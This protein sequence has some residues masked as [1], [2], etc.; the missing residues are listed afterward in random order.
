MVELRLVRIL[1][2]SRAHVRRPIRAR[3]LALHKGGAAAN[4][5]KGSVNQMSKAIVDMRN[6]LEVMFE[7]MD[8][9][10]KRFPGKKGIVLLSA[11]QQV[12]RDQSHAGVMIPYYDE[13][14]NRNFV[15]HELNMRV[16]KSVEQSYVQTVMTQG[17]I[18]GVRLHGTVQFF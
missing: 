1:F 11:V 6:A 2:D 16:Q 17:C 10:E 12:Y 5:A 14:G 4:A 13:A 15:R 9:I 8:S 7:P 18:P 3:A